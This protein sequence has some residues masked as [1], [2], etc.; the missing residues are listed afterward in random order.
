MLQATT[1]ER[2]RTQ[3]PGVQ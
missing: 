2:C 1:L 3:L